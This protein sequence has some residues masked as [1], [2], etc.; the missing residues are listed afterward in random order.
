[1]RENKKSK[2]ASTVN[3]FILLKEPFSFK[4]ALLNK[5]F[6]LPQEKRGKIR[7]CFLFGL[8]FT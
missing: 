5:I 8:L 6:F 3:I 7:L 1:M 2:L 4:D